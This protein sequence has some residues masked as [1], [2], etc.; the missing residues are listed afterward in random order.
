MDLPFLE[1]GF[2]SSHMYS[3]DEALAH[4][5]LYLMVWNYDI[6]LQSLHT[7]A[8]HIPRSLDLSIR[9][10]TSRYIV[11]LSCMKERNATVVGYPD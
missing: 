6:P 5:L 9:L 7:N 11:L 1:I 8:H 10:Y 3:A 2:L 4:G